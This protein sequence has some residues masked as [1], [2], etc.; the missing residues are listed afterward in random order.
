MIEDVRHADDVLEAPGAPEHEHVVNIENLRTYLDHLGLDHRDLAVTPLG[1]GH[2]NLTFALTAGGRDFVLRRPPR[3]T[4][5]RGTHDVIR[6]SRVLRALEDWEYAPRVVAACPETDVIGAPFYIMERAPGVVIGE[7]LPAGLDDRTSRR[8]IGARLVE[9]LAGLHSLDA[10]APSLQRLGR[11][12]SYL[13][14]QVELFSGLW[15]ANRTRDLPQVE[16][17]AS[18]LRTNLPSNEHTSVVHGDFRLGNVLFMDSQPARVSAVLDWE[19]ATLGDPYADIGYL[20]AFWVEQ[21]DLHIK[22]FELSSST[23]APGFLSRD[24]L[25][26]AYEE[27]IGRSV[28]SI[29]WY[30]TLA[31]WKVLVLMEGNYKRTITGLSDDPFNRAF[32][33]GV[34][35]LA[36]LATHV[37]NL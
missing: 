27:R 19:M 29:A 17:V 8:D 28:P 1:D 33:E 35:E 6:E 20:S 34:V 37:A 12:R 25:V 2:S 22:M 31:L 3:G 16:A 23:R 9:V 4:I 14:R 15:L 30:Q 10:S 18:W 36:D 21:D 7:E 11:P 5:E 32:D 26:S 24:E 13:Q